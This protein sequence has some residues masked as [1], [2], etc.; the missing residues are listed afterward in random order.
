MPKALRLMELREREVLKALE[1][2]KQRTGG[3]TDPRLVMV[4]GY[5]LRAY[6]RFARYTRDCDFILRKQ[7]G[8]GIEKLKHMLPPNFSVEAFEKRGSYG[9]MRCVKL[10][11]VGGIKVKVSLDFMEGEVRGRGA[12]DIVRVDEEM[13]TKSKAVKLRIAGKDFE[14]PVPRYV[15]LFIMK[16]VSAR[17]SDVRDVASMLLENG[18]PEELKQ[19][20]TQVLPFPEVFREKLSKKIMPEIMKETFL[21]S[22]RGAF[23]TSEY[24]EEHRQK[25]LRLMRKILSECL[26]ENKR[27]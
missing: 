4:G 25:V 17:P 16:V 23:A 13:V 5:A 19:R 3:F 8:W 21:N 7:D 24:T 12:R 1:W 10:A 15:D 20:L 27:N 2:L 18:V 9:F 26:S 22:W 11:N 6:V 14:L